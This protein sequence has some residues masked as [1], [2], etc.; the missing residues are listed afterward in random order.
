[1]HVLAP[2][3]CGTCGWQK[4][5]AEPQELELQVVIHSQPPWV[6]GNNAREVSAL[7]C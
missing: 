6:L 1:M 2:Q 5:E 3:A 7:N 4:L